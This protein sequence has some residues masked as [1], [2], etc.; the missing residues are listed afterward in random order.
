MG[1]KVD[2]AEVI[3][4]SDKLD[5]SYSDISSG[6]A[7]VDQTITNIRSMDS[8]SGETAQSVK[9][10]LDEFH[11][12]V[13]DS[14]DI[15]Y[16]YLSEKTNEHIEKFHSKV[17]AS[18]N[19]IVQSDYLTEVRRDVDIPYLN[20]KGCNDNVQDA[21]ED[22]SDIVSA[23]TPD[24]YSVM[25]DHKD[26][27]ET[28]DDLTDDFESFTGKGKFNDSRTKEIIKS[29]ETVINK[30]GA[31][32]GFD[33]VNN[34]EHGTGNAT[35]GEAKG[36]VS[37]INKMRTAVNGAKE[38]I[39]ERRVYNQTKNY[40]N[41]DVKHISEKSPKEKAKY[42]TKKTATGPLKGAKGATPFAKG[43]GKLLGPLSAG[44]S[45]HDNYHNAVAE[46]YEGG[47]AHIRAAEDTAV[48]TAVS[49]TVQYGLTAAG[50][51]LIPIPG[52][53]TA[54]GAAAGLVVNGLLNVEFGKSKRSVMDR[55]KSGFQKIKGWFS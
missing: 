16:E 54:A 53:G 22:V 37:S 14:F 40:K 26:A 46:G 7:K 23:S 34:A 8:F 5:S 4:F 29:I 20:F 1:Q 52:V 3:A 32:D 25:G 21:I 38:S 30:A 47:S 43:S 55:A 9:D 39:K 17:D 50:T 10:Y 27:M 45:Y 35:A 42:V 31:R 11:A 49:S 12:E 36:Y 44:L 2:I 6:V 41:S 33:R 51:A 13:L 48:E 28:I 15:L 24:F 19:A 18:E